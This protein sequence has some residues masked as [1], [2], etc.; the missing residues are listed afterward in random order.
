[1]FTETSEKYSAADGTMNQPLEKNEKNVADEYTAVEEF[2]PSTTT[3]ASGAAGD[4]RVGASYAEYMEAKAQ[5][6]EARASHERRVQEI[7][8]D[9]LGCDINSIPSLEELRRERTRLTEEVRHHKDEQDSLA[10]DIE[11]LEGAADVYQLAARVQRLEHFVKRAMQYVE[12]TLPLEVEKTVEEDRY[13]S[14]LELC[15]YIQGLQKR[16][17]NTLQKIAAVQEM[18][19]KRSRLQS[20]FDEAVDKPENED[21]MEAKAAKHTQE[22]KDECAVLHQKIRKFRSMVTKLQIDIAKESKESKK[23]EDR[24]C[25]CIRNVELANARDARLCKELN[26]RNSAVTTN[27]Q[28]L[29]DQLNV[30]H[31]GFDSTLKTRQLLEDIKDRQTAGDGTLG[32]Q[33]QHMRDASFASLGTPQSRTNS[34]TASQRAVKL[35]MVA[36]KRTESQRARDNAVREAREELSQSLRR[37]N[38]TGNNQLSRAASFS[39]PPLVAMKPTASQRSRDSALR[40]EREGALALRSRQRSNS[41]GSEVRT[42]SVSARLGA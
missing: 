22:N 19:N 13:Q 31:Y 5:L 6:E 24:M 42:P 30:E 39:K 16:R 38:S 14:N 27:S 18:M 20:A 32:D 17:T 26:S 11:G 33:S 36:M 2:A 29:M 10:L 9:S 21:P 7:A 1:M 40:E 28:L 41:L 3:V 34:M 15:A 25:A 12:E 37:T 4:A 23:M 8:Q 35:P